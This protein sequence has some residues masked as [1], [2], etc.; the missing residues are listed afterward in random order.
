MVISM[1]GR[2]SKA[3]MK[4]LKDEMVQLVNQG[5]S[6]IE[7]SEILK[8]TPSQVTRALGAVRSWRGKRAA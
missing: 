4:A 3:A 5:K 7:V 2:R 1:A 6:R 8:C